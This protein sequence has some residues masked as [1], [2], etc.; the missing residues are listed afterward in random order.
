VKAIQKIKEMVYN[1][2]TVTDD[3]IGLHE[4]KKGLL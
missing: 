1:Q 2:E 3:I 4:L